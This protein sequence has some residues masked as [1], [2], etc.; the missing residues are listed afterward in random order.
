MAKTLTTTEL[1]EMDCNELKDLLEKK[2][3]ELRK[4]KFEHAA[5][6]VKQ[7]HQFAATR[8]EIARIQTVYVSKSCKS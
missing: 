6:Q 8:K 4:Q 5:G 7:T 1:N 2:R 3:E